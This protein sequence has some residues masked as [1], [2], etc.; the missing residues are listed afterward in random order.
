MLLS[1]C[2]ILFTASNVSL[3]VAVAVVAAVAFVSAVTAPVARAAIA[4]TTILT[5]S[6]AAE[7]AGVVKPR[8]GG[9]RGV[10]VAA[11]FFLFFFFFLLLVCSIVAVAVSV[12]VPHVG[13]LSLRW[14][15]HCYT[16]FICEEEVW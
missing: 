16:R 11:F 13:R 3:V 14:C 4:G 7:T 15:R 6:G 10:L 5:G 12:I 9:G 1:P 8:S 2:K